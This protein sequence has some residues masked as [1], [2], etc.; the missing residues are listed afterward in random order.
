MAIVE[1]GLDPF[2]FVRR[3]QHIEAAA[4]R[5]R[6]VRWGPRTLDIDVLFYDDVAISS[7]DLTIPHPATPSAFVLAPLFEVAPE[8]CPSGW[9][10]SVGTEG[11]HA[12]GPLV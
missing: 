2:A 6:T 12:R 10:S 4:L 8:R 1:T 7:P 5:Q 3:C 9:E 11:V